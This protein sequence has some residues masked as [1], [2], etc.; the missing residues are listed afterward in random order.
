MKRLFAAI[1]LLGL[2]CIPSAA[3]SKITSLDFGWKFIE[4]N[5]T[6]GH[7]PAHDD[8]KWQSVALPHD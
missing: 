5:V 6:D 7:L 1:G 4:Q 2:A 3:Q 8:S